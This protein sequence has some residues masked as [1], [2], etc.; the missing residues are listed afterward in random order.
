MSEF[1]FTRSGGVNSLYDLD[2]VDGWLRCKITRGDGVYRKWK[3][4]SREA[5]LADVPDIR[6]YEFYWLEFE[7]ASA[8]ISL[9]QVRAHKPG[10]QPHDSY[11]G[12]ADKL[13]H[14][15]PV[16]QLVPHS[17]DLSFLDKYINRL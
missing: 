2:I 6:G 12:S 7:G 1:T 16:K 4:I 14:H 5:I 9:E 15:L 10:Q 17:G 8:R 13:F 3:T 11:G